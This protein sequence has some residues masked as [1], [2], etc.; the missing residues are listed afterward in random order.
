MNDGTTRQ[1]RRGRRFPIQQP[2]EY[3]VLD[4]A[5]LRGTGTSL[6]FST[7]GIAFTTDDNLPVGSMVEV[8]VDWPVKLD[9]TC[10]LKFVGVGYVLRSG[11]GRT[12]VKIHKHELRTRGKTPQPA[13]SPGG[14][15]GTA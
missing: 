2:V 13:P 14:R 1:R 9:G 15:A 3:K 5:A 11:D 7:G 4:S 10:A 8:S 12:A 6:N